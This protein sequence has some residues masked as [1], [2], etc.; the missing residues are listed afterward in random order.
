MKDVL[1]IVSLPIENE[2]D[3]VAAR[4]RV[5]RLAELVG[6]DRQDQTRIATAVSEIARNAFV[7]AGGGRAECLIDHIEGMPRLLIR[8]SDK[9]KGIGNLTDILDGRYKS[10]TGM[11]LGLIGAR[12]LMGHFRIETVP[13][14]GTTV[15]LGQRLPKGRQ[16]V[17]PKQ[18]A[19]IAETLKRETSQ[20]PLASLREQNRELMQS[21]E[22][23]GRLRSE[24]E[25]ISQ[26]LQ[27]TNRGVVALYAE[28]EERA[29]QLRRASE[30]K[31]R[32]L[33]NISHE[34]RTPLNSVLALSR[35]LLDH[36]DGDLTVEQEKQVGFIRKSAE[37]LLELVNDLLDLA[38][39][40]A[41][42]IDVRSDRFQISAL[43]GALR[44]ALRPLLTNRNVQLVFEPTD[45][46][47]D[48]VADEGKVT[49]ILRNLISNA[50]KFTTAGEVRVGA[51]F[52][53]EHGLVHF[54]VKDT[55]IGIA[56]RDQARIFEE[57]SQIENPLQRNVKGTG[58]GLPLSR[59]LAELIGGTI[60]LE[61]EIGRGSQFT[62]T[63]AATFAPSDSKPAITRV[64]RKRVLVIDDD[65]SFRYVFRQIISNDKSF[66]IIEA[67]DGQEG[68]RRARDE[69]PDVIV[70]DL[71]MP[72]IDGFSVMRE[73]KAD[74]VTS[75]IPVIVSTSLAVNS[76]LKDRLPEGARIISK[77][78]ISRDTVSLF[79]R[80][81]LGA[82]SASVPR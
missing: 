15:E 74:Q 19:E 53:P 81:A 64:D 27:D 9:G 60:E 8:I 18:S 56:P 48:L 57:F 47:P 33:S 31:T 34:F 75:P 76:D 55:G 50:L 38:K 39:V 14:K 7:Y 54:V 3:V 78:L 28:L 35:L 77:S 6:F 59:S 58:L 44:G 16:A 66:D 24:G 62:L 71:Q 13:G 69:R 72:N 40:E 45:H 79:L 46:L 80:D 10:G 11:G 26:E 82:S 63:I 42:K 65:E 1:R 70:L 51:R 32:F 36:V 2:S 52:D 23:I 37:G 67:N 20:D 30:L 21:L 43:F 25:Q 49:Q 68:L 5:R 12:R 73:L 29:E 22:E 4:Q 41:G 17:T 61:S